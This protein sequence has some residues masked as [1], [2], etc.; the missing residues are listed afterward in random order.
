MHSTTRYPL[1]SGSSQFSYELDCRNFFTRQEA[2]ELVEYLREVDVCA[3][4]DFWWEEEDR[5][6]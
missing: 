4:E 3:D 6:D 1:Q 2:D 5:Y